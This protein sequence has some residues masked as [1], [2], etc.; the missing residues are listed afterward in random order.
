MNWINS[1]NE[2]GRREHKLPVLKIKEGL[3]LDFTDG[4]KIIQNFTLRS[5][6]KYL[7]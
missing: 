1:K 6:I 2:K 5:L 4:K 7:K 3:S